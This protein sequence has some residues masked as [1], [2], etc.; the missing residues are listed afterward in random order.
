V[1]PETAKRKWKRSCCNQGGFL[2]R[3]SGCILSL[4]RFTHAPRGVRFYWVLRGYISLHLFMQA[5]IYAGPQGLRA[6][7]EAIL[8]LTPGSAGR[9]LDPAIV[10]ALLSEPLSFGRR[11]RDCCEDQQSCLKWQGLDIRTSRL[12][13]PCATGFRSDG[14]YRMAA[15]LNRHSPDRRGGCHRSDLQ[16]ARRCMRQKAGFRLI[17]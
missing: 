9:R 11:G 13:S 10:Y 6:S 12:F 17:F 16:P 4:I 2:R 5:P 3:R 1:V 7:V 14:A 8:G 15:Y